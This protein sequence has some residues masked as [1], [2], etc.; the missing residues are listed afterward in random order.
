M[1]GWIGGFCV[2]DIGRLRHPQR[3]TGEKLSHETGYKVPG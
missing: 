1:G 3:R 2:Y